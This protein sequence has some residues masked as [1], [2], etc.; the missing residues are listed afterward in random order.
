MSQLISLTGNI[1][2]GKSTVAA[3]LHKLTGWP[4]FSID[5]FRIKHN[6]KFITEEWD[7]WSDL[8][9]Q[10]MVKEVAIL[11]TTGLSKSALKLYYAF[12]RVKVV[13]LHAPL[14]TINYRIRERERSGYQWPPYCYRR[15][16]T[17]WEAAMRMQPLLIKLDHDLSFNTE[18]LS[19][20]QIAQ[21]IM[22]TIRL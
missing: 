3:Q 4:V 5:D 6:A 19:P 10:C 20:E 1:C 11:D 13:Q 16:Q 15:N 22:K 8:T 18:K 7:A 12:D 17:P 14:V 9:I 2:T 21:R